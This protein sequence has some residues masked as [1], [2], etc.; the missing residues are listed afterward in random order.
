MSKKSYTGINIQAPISQLILNGKKT[1]ETR[2]YPIPGKY[3]NQE[4]LLIETPGKSGGFKARIIGI[5]KF[6]NCFQYGNKKEFYS[7]ANKHCVTSDSIWAW[8]E[9]E[10]WGWDVEVIKRI[11][12]VLDAPKIKG[13]KYT[14][15]I[16]I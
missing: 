9:G 1:V 8:A 6:T 10:K 4:M 11:D 2:T 13:I 3:L 5:I 12:P 14:L 7:Q 15:N 16:Q